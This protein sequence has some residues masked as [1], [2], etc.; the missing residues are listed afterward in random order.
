MPPSPRLRN[1]AETELRVSTGMGQI[2]I[3]RNGPDGLLRHSGRERGQALRLPHREQALP[4]LLRRRREPRVGGAAQVDHD[5]GGDHA[6]RTG[7]GRYRQRQRVPLQGPC[8]GPRVARFGARRSDGGHHGAGAPSGGVQ[9]HPA[10]WSGADRSRPR[11][12]QGMGVLRGHPQGRVLRRG[13]VGERSHHRNGRSGAP[14]GGAA[15]HPEE[16]PKGWQ[17]RYRVHVEDYGWT[18]WVYAPFATGSVGMG[19][20]IEAVQFVLEK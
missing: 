17:L 12:E 11:L 10:R 2:Q 20:A 8:G 9:D 19:K 3:H 1:H 6:Y 13:L 7:G 15:G 14:D 18:G 4:R 5:Q 16:M